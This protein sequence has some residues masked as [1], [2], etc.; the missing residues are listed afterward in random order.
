MET[1]FYSGTTAGSVTEMRRRPSA[2]TAL[3]RILRQ[4]VEIRQLLQACLEHVDAALDGRM[5]SHFSL[6]LL[7]GITHAEFLRHLAAEEALLIP[8]LEDDLPLG[9]RRAAL[10]KEEHARQRDEFEDLRRSWDDDGLVRR[11]EKLRALS[12]ALL[13]DIEHEEREL[14]VGDVIRDDGVVVDQS[15]G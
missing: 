1:E 13:D 9:P 5:A 7:V 2:E 3:R 14:L 4:H 15:D 12:R 10:L 8:I 11:A 6:R